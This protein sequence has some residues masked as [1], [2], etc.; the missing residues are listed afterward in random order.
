VT[1]SRGI[2]AALAQAICEAG[3]NVVIAD[4]PEDKAQASTAVGWPSR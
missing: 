2:G 1:A 4:I 3:A